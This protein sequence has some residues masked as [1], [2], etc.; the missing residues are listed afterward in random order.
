MPLTI[1]LL[2]KRDSVLTLGVISVLSRERDTI[3]FETQ[4]ESDNDLLIDSDMQP[5]DVV[6]VEIGAGRSDPLQISYIFER[7]PEAT[8]VAINS[9]E[10]WVKLHN[11]HEAII[12]EPAELIAA[13]HSIQARKEGDNKNHSS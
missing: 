7:F 3:L 11:R 8:V 2:T 13:I 4:L 5:P 6:V 10:N 1:I 12:R 9:L